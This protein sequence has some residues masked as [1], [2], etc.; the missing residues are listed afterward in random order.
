MPATPPRGYEPGT[1]FTTQT[2]VLDDTGPGGSGVLITFGAA[3]KQR[4]GW[5][6]TALTG[7]DSPDLPEAAQNKT[8]AD[9][10]WDAANYYS[11]RQI[12]LEGLIQAP[13]PAAL[14]AAMDR[15]AQALPARR[16]VAFTVNETTP[17]QAAIRRSGRLMM[18]KLTDVVA[19]FSIAMLAPDPRK[20]GIDTQTA[21][22]SLG[23]PGGG[24][25]LP[26]ALPMSVPGRD[27][28]GEFFTATNTGADPT[29]PLIR[30]A[31]PGRDLGIANLTTG[32]S[33]RYAFELLPGDELVI[34][35]DAGAAQLNG[36]AYRS[37]APGSTVTSLFLLPPG[38]SRM[39]FLGART[40]IAVTPLLTA[41]WRAAWM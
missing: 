32:Q 6:Y 41:S 9:G 40:D 11:G 33:L 15:L 30:I 38:T 1:V 31:G 18:A 10:M 26:L 13:A 21:T 25:A 27:P 22:G 20:Y 23:V 7:W 12:G 36:A 5:R 24:V 28:G 3:D 29:P 16:L 35:T 4:V 34:D 8:G 37:P 14:D 19:Q 17:K 2:A 39:R